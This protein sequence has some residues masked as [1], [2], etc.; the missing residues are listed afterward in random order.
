MGRTIALLVTA[1]ALG[2]SGAQAQV[3]GGRGCPDEV[4]RDRIAS[5]EASGEIALGSGARAR[6]VDVRLAGP[7]DGAPAGRPGAL[8]WLGSLA[9]QAVEVR[10]AGP[11]D[12]WGRVPA[13]LALPETGAID[14]AELL[15]SEGLALVDIG[16]RDALCRPDLLAAEGKA[17]AARRGLWASSPFPL[18]AREPEALRAAAGR[19]ALVE[20]RIVSVGERA[21][22]TYLNFGRDFARDFAAVIPKRQWDALKRSGIDAA[23]L[24]GRQVRVRGIVEV[25]RAPTIEIVATD[26]LEVL[27]VG[28]E[29]P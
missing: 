1:L 4:V 16:E 14:V 5:V 7:E 13:R 12:R 19:F 20:G 22:R 11:A 25:R 23:R 26:M 27:E 28:P 18:P 6:L 21:A 17:R 15:V 8:A 3:G 24:K 2:A 29:R 10:A 9:G